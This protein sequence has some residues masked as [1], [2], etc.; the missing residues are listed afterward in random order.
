MVNVE[1]EVGG[2]VYKI[3]IVEVLKNVNK[4]MIEVIER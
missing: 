1:I 3:P 4:V 2:N